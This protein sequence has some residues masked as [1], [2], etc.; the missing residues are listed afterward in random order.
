MIASI[1]AAFKLSRALEINLAAL[2]S[3]CE[4]G[5]QQRVARGIELASI[6]S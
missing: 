5:E 3:H 1:V 2:L 4:R 6:A